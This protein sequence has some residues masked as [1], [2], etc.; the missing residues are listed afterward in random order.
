MVLVD[1][2]SAINV[3]PFHTTYAVGL[4]PT[5]FLPTAQMIRAYDNTSK[6][7]TGVAKVQ[8]QV[9]LLNINIDPSHF[10][11]TLM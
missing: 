5:D 8:V 10:I 4:T 2:G 3:C 7:V 1:T 9:G 6:E 11:S